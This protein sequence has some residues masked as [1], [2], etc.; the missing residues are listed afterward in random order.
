MSASRSRKHTDNSTSS[1]YPSCPSTCASLRG[2]HTG[3]VPASQSVH[4]ALTIDLV[5]VNHGHRMQGG[6]GMGIFHMMLVSI[7]CGSPDL[8]LPPL[9]IYGMF[10]S[11]ACHQSNIKQRTYYFPWTHSVR[12]NAPLL[13]PISGFTFSFVFVTIGYASKQ[14]MN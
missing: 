3:R 7:F 11:R 8:P 2:P 14:I 1:T 12:C 13:Y 9:A 4:F 10:R 5:V 6:G